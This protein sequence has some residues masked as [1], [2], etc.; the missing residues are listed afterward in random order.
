[1][2]NLKN[3]KSKVKSVRKN[4]G[5]E[6]NNIITKNYD[7]DDTELDGEKVMMNIEKGKYFMINEVGSSIWDYIEEPT[8]VND[9]IKKLCSEYEVEEVI[10]KN[11]VLNFL[12]ELNKVGLIVIR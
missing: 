7:I 12:T 9:I 11:S 6:L 8:S 10:C 2:I 3:S 4:L 5:I 1:M